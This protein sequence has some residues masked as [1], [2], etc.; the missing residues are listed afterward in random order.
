MK[1]QKSLK[2][3]PIRENKI[4]DRINDEFK[5][6]CARFSILVCVLSSLFYISDGGIACM[7][8]PCLYGLCVDDVNR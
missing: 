8:N 2:R 7:S 3:F 6:G 1:D 5:I 4:P